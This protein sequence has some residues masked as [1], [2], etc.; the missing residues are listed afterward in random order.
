MDKKVMNRVFEGLILLLI[1]FATL[2]QPVAVRSN[3]A[4]SQQKVGQARGDRN[5]ATT[6]AMLAVEVRHRLVMLP[7]YDVFDWLEG[8]VKA[9]GTVVLRGQ[10]VR[11][12][13]KTDAEKSVRDIADITRVVNEI[14]VLPL[15]SND[16]Q[17]RLALY[18]AIYKFDSPLFKYAT[19]AVPPIHI[20]V[21]NGRITLK[22]VVATK[23]D[24]D[25][26]YMAARNVSGLFEV[27]NELRAE[28]QMPR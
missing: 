14:E 17:L 6:P 2:T 18:R 22:G 15:S 28:D 20:I 24:S 27:T 5:T 8:D 3:K 9:D 11:P 7:S 21:K 16:D 10:T 25:L 4:F 26:A 19:R 12:T 13:L 23:A 1:L